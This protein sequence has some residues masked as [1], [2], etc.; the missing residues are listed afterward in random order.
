[1][2]IYHII[3]SNIKYISRYGLDLSQFSPQKKLFQPYH[4]ALFASLKSED[5]GQKGEGKGNGKKDSTSFE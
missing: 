1:M 3:T 4:K 2:I 5:F